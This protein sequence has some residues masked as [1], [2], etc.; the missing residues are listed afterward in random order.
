MNG[1][2]SYPLTKWRPGITTA[3]AA[4]LKLKFYGFLVRSLRIKSNAVFKVN[5]AKF[6]NIVALARGSRKLLTLAQI[7]AHRRNGFGRVH[8]ISA[9]RAA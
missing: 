5:L 3:D 4:D 7:L 2:T 9:V 1:R 6:P 8:G